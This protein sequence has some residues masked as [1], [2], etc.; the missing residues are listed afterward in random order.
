MLYI[1]PTDKKILKQI[2][3]DHDKTQT[4]LLEEGLKYI[5]EK[6]KK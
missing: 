1:E 5:I 4:E 3:L 6:Y 2:A